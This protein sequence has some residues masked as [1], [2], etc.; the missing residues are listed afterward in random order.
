MRENIIEFNDWV[1]NQVGQL[2]AC[3][4]ETTDL[5]AYLWKMYLVTPDWE[6]V[7]YIKFILNKYKDACMNYSAKQ[8]M[9][10]AGNK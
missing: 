3:G 2:H 10:L 1:H 6:F 7:D 5:L 4:E 9:M 8:L